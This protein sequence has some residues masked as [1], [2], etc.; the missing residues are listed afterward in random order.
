MDALQL[1]I[2][3]RHFCKLAMQKENVFVS[4][5]NI[6]IKFFSKY[7]EIKCKK[8]IFVHLAWTFKK[9]HMKTSTLWYI[10]FFNNL[11]RWSQLWDFCNLITRWPFDPLTSFIN[12]KGK[13]VSTYNVGWVY[14]SRRC[15]CSHGFRWDEV[16]LTC[17]VINLCE[18]L[19][20]CHP[21]RTAECHDIGPN[22]YALVESQFQNL[23][24]CFVR[25]ENLI[26]LTWKKVGITDPG[27]RV[28]NPKD[29]FL[30]H[31]PV[32]QHCHGQNR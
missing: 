26:K 3:S 20:P 12:F 8:T 25:I 28:C 5:T 4:K 16:T 17:D 18:E 2:I 23:P 27:S 29:N 10:S 21:N 14:W 9:T 31:N 32:L 19:D 22:Q 7:D 13:Q 24:T 30:R 6:C 1:K 11:I 15:R